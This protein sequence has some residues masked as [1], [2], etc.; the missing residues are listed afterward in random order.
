MAGIKKLLIPID[1]S[2]NALR[3]LAYATQRLRVAKHL[4]MCLLNVQ[5]PL[6]AS[7]FVTQAMIDQY[8]DSHSKAALTR[9][10]RRIRTD[11]RSSRGNRQFRNPEALQ[12]DCHGH[13]RPG[14]PKE[15]SARFGHSKGHS[16]ARVP[17]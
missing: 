16:P 14:K 10:R 9:E 1:G 11:W 15:F 4:Q 3:A 5:L 17:V 8:Y 7:L 6:P 12:R 13:A 2:D